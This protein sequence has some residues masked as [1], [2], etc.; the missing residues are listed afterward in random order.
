MDNSRFVA[1]G[2]CIGRLDSGMRTSLWVICPPSGEREKAVSSNRHSC[3]WICREGDSAL[4][5][6]FRGHLAI[7]GTREG[8]QP[9]LRCARGDC[10]AGVGPALA[11]QLANVPPPQGRLAWANQSRSNGVR[12]PPIIFHTCF[13][14]SARAS[15]LDFY[16]DRETSH[17]WRRTREK[18]PGAAPSG[19]GFHRAAWPRAGGA[20]DRG[21]H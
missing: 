19:Q 17:L 16:R 18:A 5:R 10:G 21:R 4:P 6:R 9:R 12:R 3:P 7:F 2:G 11:C 15:D 13:K 14:G 1:K 8:R 20:V